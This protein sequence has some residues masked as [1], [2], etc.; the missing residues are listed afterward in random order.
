MGGGGGIWP[1]GWG[2]PNTRFRGEHLR[3]LGHAT[4]NQRIG[5]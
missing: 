5:A 4:A 2:L 3:P 1:P